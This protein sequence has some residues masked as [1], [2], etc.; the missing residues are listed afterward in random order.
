MSTG[1]AKALLACVIMA[2]LGGCATGE[3][4]AILSEIPD[5]TAVAAVQP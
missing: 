2:A 5:E 4:Q 3:P 1:S